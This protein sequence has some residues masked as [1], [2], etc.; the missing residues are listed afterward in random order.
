MPERHSA[1]EY[2]K[3]FPSEDIPGIVQ[4]I[5]DVCNGLKRQDQG[6]IENKLSFRLYKKLVWLPAYRT[7]PLKVVPLWESPI[8]NIAEE[9][10]EITGRADILFLFPGG[11]LEAYFLVEAKRLF[12]TSSKGKV[13][14][15]T[16]KYVD[17][18]MMRFVSG[19]YASK[20]VA[21]A[22]LG[23]VFDKPVADAKIALAATVK[24]RKNILKMT[25]EGEWQGSGLS[26]SPSVDETRHAFDQGAFTIYHILTQV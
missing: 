1:A 11:G 7:G 8:V 2:V 12:V 13:A 25:D 10:A 3:L 24:K 9:N 16:G 20:M 23:Y 6:E 26:V 22:M 19:Q 21:G 17:E 18:G 5:I 4:N 14:P 15:L